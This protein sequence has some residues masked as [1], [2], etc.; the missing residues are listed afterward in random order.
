MFVPILF[1]SF[2]A[3]ARFVRLP[4]YLFFRI[5][6]V[7]CRLL[8]VN[9]IVVYMFRIMVCVFHTVEYKNRIVELGLLQDKSDFLMEANGLDEKTQE[10]GEAFLLSLFLRFIAFTA[11][12]PIAPGQT[13]SSFQPVPPFRACT[14][15]CFSCSLSSCLHRLRCRPGLPRNR[16]SRVS[17]RF[18]V[19]G[20]R[21]LFH[22]PQSG[23]P[24]DC[25]RG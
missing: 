14:G 2:A 24:P 20:R 5:F 4:F 7:F 22:N 19:S 16:G 23:L 12:S 11:Y 13:T 10:H 8:S 17:G 18:P 1:E 9:R 3:F 6:L 21:R 25:L 15:I